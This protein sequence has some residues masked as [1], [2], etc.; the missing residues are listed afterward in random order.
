[1]V[2]LLVLIWRKEKGK[3]GKV[4]IPKNIIFPS[5]SFISLLI[6]THKHKREREELYIL[7]SP[8]SVKEEITWASAGKTRKNSSRMAAMAGNWD[9]CVDALVSIWS[10]FSYPPLC[11][12]SM[13]DRT[14]LEC[15][16]PT[17]LLLLSRLCVWCDQ[18][19]CC[20]RQIEIKKERD[21]TT[22]SGAN[23][24]LFRLSGLGVLKESNVRKTE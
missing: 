12:F 10:I 8:G 11:L 24:H 5:H 1:M 22:T 19:H 15:C 3:Q 6:K 9:I 13:V 20:Q 21:R 23:Y 2:S 17:Y 4:F 18:N 14:L 16:L 7:P